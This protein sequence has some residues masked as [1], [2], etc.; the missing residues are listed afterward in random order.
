[1]STKKL[2]RLRSISVYVPHSVDCGNQ[3]CIDYLAE[4][5]GTNSDS[6]I[7]FHY[8]VHLFEEQHVDQSLHEMVSDFVLDLVSV[9]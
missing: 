4:S 7:M 8:V 3:E 6:M 1:M 5:Y 9:I 2:S